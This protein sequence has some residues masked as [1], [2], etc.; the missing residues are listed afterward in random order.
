MKH[1]Y[2][3]IN[4]SQGVIGVI[5]RIGHLVDAIVGFAVSIETHSHCRTERKKGFLLLSLFHFFTCCVLIFFLMYTIP[6][7]VK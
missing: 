5:E 2:L 1:S 6:Y 4:A 7:S 3:T